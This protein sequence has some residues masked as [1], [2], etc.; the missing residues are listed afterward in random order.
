MARKDL[1]IFVNATS[2]QYG[3]AEYT[4]STDLQGPHK[5]DHVKN[6]DIIW[7]YWNQIFRIEFV[8]RD[9][10]QPKLN[11][12]FRD[13]SDGGPI[14]I[15]KGKY[16]DDCPSSRFIDP[17]Y[18]VDKVRQN[19]FILE[20]PP[21]GN[22]QTDYVFRLRIADDQD[23]DQDYDPV[24]ENGGGGFEPPEAVVGGLSLTL[25]LGLLFGVAAL[26]GLAYFAGWL[27]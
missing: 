21:S 2:N 16:P 19:R 7:T 24:I 27:T 15:K 17:A 9:N 14:W 8:I 22:T 5:H 1:R 3:K 12:R 10:T 4:L 11:L 6:G 13:E 23:K 18:K 26:A 25:V 20:N